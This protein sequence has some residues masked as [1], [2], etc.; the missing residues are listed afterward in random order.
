MRSKCCMELIYTV[1]AGQWQSKIS[2]CIL[3]VLW[4]VRV[5][6]YILILTAYIMCA[7]MLGF[8]QGVIKLHDSTGVYCSLWS[9]ELKYTCTKFSFYCPST[10]FEAETKKSFLAYFSDFQYWWWRMGIWW[11]W[12]DKYEW[13]RWWTD[14]SQLHVNSS[15]K[16]CC[17][18]WCVGLPLSK[19][20]V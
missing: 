15:H 6:L 7:A 10:K 5:C 18:R 19:F 16:L 11:N 14:G 2:L 20:A 8:P 9:R 17:A 13:E 12:D 3:E 4:T 1:S